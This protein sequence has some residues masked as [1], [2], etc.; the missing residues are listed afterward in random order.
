VSTAFSLGSLLLVQFFIKE[1]KKKKKKE[2]KET[3][4]TPTGI[5]DAPGQQPNVWA[6]SLLGMALT[7]P[8]Y[9]VTG[10]FFTILAVKLEVTTGALGWIKILAYEAAKGGYFPT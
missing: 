9:M 7:A 4:N 8:A 10:E 5:L 2:K 6:F 1:K 3:S